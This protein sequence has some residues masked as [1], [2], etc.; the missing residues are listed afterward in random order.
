MKNLVKMK[1]AAF[2]M[3]GIFALPVAQIIGPSIP[4]HASALAHEV[5]GNAGVPGLVGT[6]IVEK[7]ATQQN[8]A[9]V[10][11]RSISG[12]EK[13]SRG[14]FGGFP[15]GQQPPQ[16]GGAGSG[17][18]IDAQGY[19][20][21][22]HHV[23][24]GSQ[25]LKVSLMDGKEYDAKVI[26][27]DPKTDIALIKIEASNGE[28]FPFIKLGD[29]D[30]LN[31]GEWVVAIGNPFGLTHSVTVGVVS[32]KHR[33]IGAGPYDEFI[34][35]DAS[36]NPGNSGGPL[37]NLQG[38][39]IGINTAILPGQSGG[40]IGI[41][42]ALPINMAKTILDDLKTDGKVTRGWLGVMIQQI[43]PELAEAMQL[44]M[45]QK[46]AL[47]SDVEPGG[48]ADKGGLKRGDVIVK[49]AGKIIDAMDILPK[50]VAAVHPG[51]K[52]EV[53]ILRAGKSQVLTLVPEAMGV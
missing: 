8:P 40:N 48:P 9:V 35:T 27:A 22:N 52:V 25:K 11:V 47:V 31:V 42:F 17:F 19:I 33:N 6:N 10:G 7:I 26:G 18:L 43:T 41:G 34:Q 32:A 5:S 21:T 16:Q 44:S 28:T 29:S 49:F 3:I 38:E 12:F 13:M 23:V 39:V 2:L 4:G 45:D 51:D 1:L 46:G 15:P 53:E 20:L 30:R 36:I 24:D 37:V 14:P 50:S